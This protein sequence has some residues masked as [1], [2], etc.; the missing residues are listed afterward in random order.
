MYPIFHL[1]V[2]TTFLHGHIKEEIHVLQPPGFIVKG[3]ER[4]ACK[5]FKALYG[6]RQSPPAW[7]ERI[8]SFLIQQGF[9]RGT[10]D[11]NLYI[12]CLG[13]DIV[14]LALYVDDILL[15]GSSSQLCSSTKPLLETNFEMSDGLVTLY[16]KAELLQVLSGVFI[17][18]KGYCKQVLETFGLLN[19]NPISTPMAERPRLISNMQEDSIDP[20]LYRSMVGNFYI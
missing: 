6:L 1:D 17:P 3:K 5:L 12:Y 16:L 7:Y 10:C 2:K 8:D 18:Q 13:H 11:S 4:L 15:T 19:S 20:A 9:T 14:L